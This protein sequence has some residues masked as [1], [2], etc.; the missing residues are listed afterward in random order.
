MSERTD[1]ISFYVIGGTIMIHKTAIVSEKAKIGH[2]VKI[3]AFTTIYDNV[4][5]EDN[6]EIGPY[7]E[8]GIESPLSEGLPLHIGHDSLIR[9]H[10]IFYEGSSIGNGLRTGHRVTVRELSIIGEQFQLGTLSD[11]Q[12]H[13]RIGNYVRTHSNVHIGQK[14]EIG[15]YVWI[16]PYTVFTNDPHPPSNTR[17]GIFV[18]DYAVIATMCVILPGVKIGQHSLVGA[19][20]LV[21]RDVDPR[22]IVVGSPAKPMGP[23][24]KIKLLDNPEKSAYPWTT[25]YHK[26]YSQNDIDR[27]MSENNE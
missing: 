3:G 16:F 21:I 4:I 11:V 18:E 10:S 1:Q 26:G 13:C 25:H 7:C 9:S 20:S 15:N 24:T 27:W 17:L 12:G 23:T 2:G 5:I 8:L 22:T 14:T 6:T 19:H